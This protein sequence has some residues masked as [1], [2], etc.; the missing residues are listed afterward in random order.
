MTFCCQILGRGQFHIVSAYGK[1]LYSS[2]LLQMAEA[3]Y[4]RQAH[5]QLKA[6]STPLNP[7]MLNI[8]EEYHLLGRLASVGN[9]RWH[10]V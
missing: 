9:S 4:P 7:Q 2:F 6:L 3:T 8:I 5:L 10:Y 1:D